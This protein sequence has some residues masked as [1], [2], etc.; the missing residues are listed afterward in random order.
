MSITLFGCNDKCLNSLGDQTSEFRNLD[1]FDKINIGKKINLFISIDSV[2]SVRIDAGENIIQNIVTDV[3]DEGWLT[4][5]DQN[6]C[7]W[8]RTYDHEINMYVALP[9]LVH[10][11]ASNT[12]N[13]IGLDTIRTKVFRFDQQIASGVNELTIVSDTA[14]IKLHTGTGDMTCFGETKKL[15]IYSSSYGYVDCKEFF[16]PEAWVTARN[17]GDVQVYSSD[18]LEAFIHSEGNIHLY[19]GADRIYLNRTGIGELFK[20]D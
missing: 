18:S 3:D 4:I 9:E 19:G 20:E 11:F 10:L 13:I 16:T 5:T 14:F 2:Y 1:G 17:S 6:T 8:I 12:G 15:Y 7:D